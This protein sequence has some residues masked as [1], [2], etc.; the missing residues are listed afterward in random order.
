M[1]DKNTNEKHKMTKN[2]FEKYVYS[3]K[4]YFFT[5]VAY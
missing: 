1:C 4:G 3:I 5:S 2:M